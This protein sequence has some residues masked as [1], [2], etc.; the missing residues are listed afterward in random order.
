MESYTFEFSKK[1]AYGCTSIDKHTFR[2][3]LALQSDKP[4]MIQRTNGKVYAIDALRCVSKGETSYQLDLTPFDI[5]PGSLVTLWP[6]DEKN[7]V[8]LTAVEPSESMWEKAGVVDA[9]VDLQKRMDELEDE[10]F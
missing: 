2:K 4:V 6:H 8:F 3:D 9:I 7:H 1:D 10:L 5:S